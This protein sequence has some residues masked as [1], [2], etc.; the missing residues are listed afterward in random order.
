MPHSGV[1]SVHAGPVLADN[2]RAVVDGAE[3]NR[4]YR[5]RPVSLY[6]LSTANSSAI[7]S[8]GP[9]AVEGEWV[10]DLKRW[11]DKRWIDTYAKHLGTV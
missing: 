4:S 1:H 5:P 3:L 8:Y 7:A 11:I 10:N 6:I 9:V 2:L